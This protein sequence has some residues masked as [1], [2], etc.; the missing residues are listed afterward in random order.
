M[1]GQL[2]D[3]FMSPT[4]T[5]VSTSGREVYIASQ[6]TTIYADGGTDVLLFASKDSSMGGGILDVSVQGYLID[7]S[8]AACA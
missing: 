7:C 2:E 8:V 4:F 6:Q 1:N 3:Y 5:G